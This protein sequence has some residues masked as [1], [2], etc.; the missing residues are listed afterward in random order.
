MTAGR[1]VP[2]SADRDEELQV[3]ARLL[4]LLSGDEQ[5][6]ARAVVR[7]LAAGPGSRSHTLG[8]VI[9][10]IEAALQAREPVPLTVE[11]IL[12]AGEDA[13]A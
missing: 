11:G 9:A 4:A 1:E 7:D 8:D 13:G 12:S 5:E 2:V 3:A 6:A 10:A